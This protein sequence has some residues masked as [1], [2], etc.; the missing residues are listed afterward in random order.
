MGAF[1]KQLATLA[2]GKM[3]GSNNKATFIVKT[4]RTTYI[5]N[6]SLI[7]VI[8]YTAYRNERVAPGEASFPFPGVK[9]LKKKFSPDRPEQELS[10][11]EHKQWGNSVGNSPA[12]TKGSGYVYPFD[13][14]K[15]TTG[16]IDQGQDFGG[17]GPIYAIGDCRILKTG[18]PGWPGGGGV[19]YQLLN[20]P[21]AGQI[22]FVYE[23]IKVT[24]KKHDVVKAGHLIGEFIPFSPTGIEIGFAD[25]SGVPLSHAEYVEGK[26]TVHGKE[27]A[28]FL[29]GLKG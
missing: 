6:G 27:M 15:A 11:F 24:V 3:A 8:W 12:N 7:A 13:P 4:L 20:G 23:G 29:A 14:F 5:V 10:H 1:L 16:R 18:A 26:E 17:T 22:I 19:L 2:V 28:A 9:D 21:R 25:A